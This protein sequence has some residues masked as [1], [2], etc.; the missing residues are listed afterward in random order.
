MFTTPKP[1]N[2]LVLLVQH[3]GHTLCS[4]LRRSDFEQSHLETNTPREKLRVGVRWGFE[5]GGKMES[6]IL[7]KSTRDSA[8]ADELVRLD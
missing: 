1:Q 5:W 7:E 3:I 4:V 6:R 2:S 8:E